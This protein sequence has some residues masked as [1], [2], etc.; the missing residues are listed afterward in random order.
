M[1]DSVVVLLALDARR[2]G[3]INQGLDTTKW[4]Q[5]LV[6][7][8]LYGE[9]WLLSYEANRQGF[10]PRTEDYVALNSLFSKLKNAG[11]SFYDINAP[12]IIPPNE[13]SGSSGQD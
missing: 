13:N 1:S 12:L 11:V 4:E 9:Q 3:R 2:R 5:F 8:E 6:K 10:L 7:E